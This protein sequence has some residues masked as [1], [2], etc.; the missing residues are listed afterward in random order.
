MT[1]L[2]RR[3]FLQP[4]WHWKGINRALLSG[5][6]KA[7]FT[8]YFQQKR[9]AIKETEESYNLE[10][11]FVR[12]ISKMN[13]T[14]LAHTCE[15]INRRKMNNHYMWE[16]VHDR[17]RTIRNSFSADELV[18]MLNAYC[19]SL[20][21]DPN[22]THLV[23]LFWDLLEDKLENLDYLS[24]IALYSCAEKTKNEK[25]MEQ[26]TTLLQNALLKNGSPQMKLTERGLQII[27]K[28][29]CKNEKIVIQKEH[30][31]SVGELIQKMDV[32]EVRN[33]LLC[34]F[35][36]FKY[37]SFDEPFLG[38][39]KKI[40]ELL[41]FKKINPCTVFHCLSV[42]PKLCNDNPSALQ[43]VRST[44]CVAHLAQRISTGR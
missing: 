31:T 34:L 18:V 27:L 42:T 29:F 11:A 32:K 20:S 5:E 8:S 36:F 21:F 25:K 7:P 1:Y 41:I 37:N 10:E 26:I 2:W 4:A 14:A 43:G 33:V 3:T 35:F 17:V 44:L 9:E 39:L 16:L 19:N 23:N 6:K 13:N 15:D 22:F 28:V 30:V 38:I 40:Q 24:H 12:R